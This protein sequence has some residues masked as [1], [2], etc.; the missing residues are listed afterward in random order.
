MGGAK[1]VLREK[2]RHITSS[3]PPGYAERLMH[4]TDMIESACRIY[5][6]KGLISFGSCKHHFDGCGGDWPRGG[7]HW[8]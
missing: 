5:A 7:R 1:A 2:N 6:A 3:T 8:T 4:Y